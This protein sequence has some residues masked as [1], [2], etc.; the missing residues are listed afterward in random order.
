MV[1]LIWLILPTVIHVAFPSDPSIG[2]GVNVTDNGRVR[3]PFR[4]DAH[5]LIVPP[6]STTVYL[7]EL[8]PT[9]IPVQSKEEDDHTITW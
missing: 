1:I 5:T 4:R 2:S 9:V 7:V 8:K 3:L 6:P